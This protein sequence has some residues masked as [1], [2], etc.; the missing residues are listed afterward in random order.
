MLGRVCWPTLAYVTGIV[1]QEFML[2]NE[3]RAAENRILRGK[4][5]GRMPL[6][7]G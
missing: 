3:Y 5:K 6:S 4:I 2:R 1:N 7:G